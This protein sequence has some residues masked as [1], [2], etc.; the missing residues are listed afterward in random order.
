MRRAE[1][2]EYLGKNIRIKLFDGDIYTGK[3]CKSGNEEFRDD[4]NLYIPRNY[5]FL[6]EK[7]ETASCLFRCSHVRKIKEEQK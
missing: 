3:L 6:T 2:E 5:Y 4:A 1:L 7:G